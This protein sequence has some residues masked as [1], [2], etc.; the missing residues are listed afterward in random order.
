M[1]KA[2]DYFRNLAHFP[3]VCRGWIASLAAALYVRESN[4]WRREYFTAH[5]EINYEAW[6]S[7]V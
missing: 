5:T 7:V 3:Q 6:Q 2:V 1:E 4:A